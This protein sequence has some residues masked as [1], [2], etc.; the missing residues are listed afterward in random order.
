[1]KL[2]D[3][4]LTAESLHRLA[5]NE[6]SPV[7]LQLIE[8][9]VDQ[10]PRCAE[11]LQREASAEWLDD[12]AVEILMTPERNLMTTYQDDVVVPRLSYDHLLKFLGPTD[13]PH[14]LGRIDAYEI[15]GIVGRGGMGVVFKAFDPALQRFV[16]IK[17]MLPHFAESGP[18]RI[19]FAREAKAAAA[20]VNDYVLPI[21]GVA[22]WQGIP[23]IV[24][25]Y[26]RGETLQKRIETVGPLD[27]KEVLRIASQLA[28]GLAAAHAQG[29]VHRDV[30]PANI[31]LDQGIERVQLTDFGLARAIDDASMTRTGVL[32]GTP[33][34]MSPEQAR[35]ENLDSRS[36]LFALGSVMYTMC[37]GRP[38]FRGTQPLAVLRKIEHEPHK[39]VQTL[40]ADIPAPLSQIIDHLLEKR[41]EDRFSSAQELAQWLDGYLSYLQQPAHQVKPKLPPS[42]RRRRKIRSIALCVS[43]AILVALTGLYAWN[44]WLPADLS[45][46]DSENSSIH[47]SPD[48][49]APPESSPEPLPFAQRTLKLARLIEVQEELNQLTQEWEIFDNDTRK[50]RVE[51]QQIQDHQETFREPL[52]EFDF[53]NQEMDALK[54]SLDRYEQN[55]PDR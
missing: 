38:P 4:C 53:L 27:V 17:M 54:R 33:Q 28:K 24:S 29:L 52:S 22:E 1:M 5:S 43:T 55:Y 34:F 45:T 14:R 44:Q 23:Y 39:S 31:L 21:Y 37:T 3:L 6:L 46:A 48:P 47:F 13:D 2:N 41:V 20:V 16:A 30:K 12:S 10:C 9:H 35:G 11:M 36:D 25:Q 49:S 26:C 19:R 50:F 18:A 15:V 42:K 40:N 51:L 8:R 7:E 32:A